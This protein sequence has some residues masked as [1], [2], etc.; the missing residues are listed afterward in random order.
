MAKRNKIVVRNF[1]AKNMPTSGSGIHKDKK[2]KY[3]SRRIQN[4]EWK[5]EAGL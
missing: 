1:V 2:G 4:R 3:A 5:K